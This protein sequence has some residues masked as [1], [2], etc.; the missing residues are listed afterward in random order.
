LLVIC[1]PLQFVKQTALELAYCH[2]TGQAGRDQHERMSRK[3]RDQGR[4]AIATPSE[5]K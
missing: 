2:D 3:A 4:L 5:T 1:L